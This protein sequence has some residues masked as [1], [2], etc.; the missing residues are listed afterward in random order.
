MLMYLF[1]FYFFFCFNCSSWFKLFFICLAL[2]NRYYC[3]FLL[4]VNL[5]M[6]FNSR[7]TM[8]VRLSSMASPTQTTSLA[9][10]TWLSPSL[11]AR[12]TMNSKINYLSIDLFAIYMSPFNLFNNWIQQNLLTIFCN[13]KTNFF[14]PSN[15]HFFK[16][17]SH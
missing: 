5:Y 16:T 9:V 7:V 17:W 2:F 15:F 3:L 6:S 11:L 4:K 13:N 1:K 8:K 14:K 10:S 12:V